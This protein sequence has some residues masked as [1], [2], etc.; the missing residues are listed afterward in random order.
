MN[1]KK[2]ISIFLI[3]VML[4]GFSVYGENLSVYDTLISENDPFVEK[5]V[6]SGI[7]SEKITFFFE[8]F[9]KEISTLQVPEYR[10]DME[11]YFLNILF[12][13]VLEKEENDEMCFVFDTV[14]QDEFLY[15]IE[16]DMA[17]PPLFERFFILSVGDLIKEKVYYP[18]QIPE[19]EEPKNEEEIPPLEEEKPKVEMYNDLENYEWAKTY[20]EELSKKEIIHGYE[21]K[22]FK[23]EGYLTRAEAI[24]II[25]STFLKTGYVVLESEFNDVTKDKWYYKYVVNAEYYSLFAKMYGDNF[26]GDK[27][28]TRQEFCGLVYR[29][30]TKTGSKLRYNHKG[31]TFYDSDNI[32]NFAYEAVT[33]MQRAGI[34][35]GMPNGFFLPDK[36]I[37]RAEASKIVYLLLEEK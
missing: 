29:A 26:E 10:E 22:T 5:I 18:P 35:N 27:Y 13:T 23:P 16:N 17:L 12:N 7:E 1:I 36:S 20:I 15:M 32:K 34:I 11:K 6:G 3:S 9:E 31:I 14:F 8:D 4:S 33:V 21:D 28:I 2:I 37:T 30:Y 24:K 25:T 19:E